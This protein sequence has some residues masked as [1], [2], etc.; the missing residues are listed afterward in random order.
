MIILHPNSKINT[1]MVVP[2]RKLFVICAAYLLL[3]TCA[4]LVTIY[5]PK[6][7]IA[8]HALILFVL[9]LHSARESDKDKNL[10]TFLMALVL[11]PLIRILSLSMPFIHF[12]TI[13]GFLLIS[14]PIFIAI[15]TC[16]RLQG[17][18]AKDVGLSMPKLNLKH[19][20]IGAGV[21]LLAIPFGIV[22]YLILKPRPLPE[23]GI[24]NFITAALIFIACTGLLEELA[25]RGLLQY[26]AIRL[27]NKWWGILFVS[28][29][30]GVLHVGNLSP[31]HL[32]C[33]LAF[34]AGF[35]FSVVRERT[36]SIY[37]ISLSHGIINIILFLVMPFYQIF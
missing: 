29:I 31:W 13:S 28:M 14:I 35:V 25:F 24:A 1:K 9:L 12:S 19:Q 37:G 11:A 26:N 32:D 7:G 34:S 16:M 18:R 3:I 22:E 21:I 15:F 2:Q 5:D 20:S 6:A 33:V 27:L 10:S 8:S 36:R 30:F 4:E 23:S 17:L